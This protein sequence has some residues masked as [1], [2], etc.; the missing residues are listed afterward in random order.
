VGLTLIPLQISPGQDREPHDEARQWR[1]LNEVQSAW[2]THLTESS[3]RLVSC[4]PMN[5]EKIKSGPVGLKPLRAGKYQSKTVNWKSLRPL[6]DWPGKAGKHRWCAPET[7]DFAS[8]LADYW[9]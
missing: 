9:P 1:L 6:Q 2:P 4:L 8:P 5:S 7:V 3:D